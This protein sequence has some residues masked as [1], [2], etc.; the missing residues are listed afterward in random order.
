MLEQ[1]Q[2]EISITQELVQL[3]L[4]ASAFLVLVMVLV[5]VL[6]IPGAWAHPQTTW[7]L[8]FGG[9][10]PCNE[11]GR[12]AGGPEEDKQE[13]LAHKQDYKHTRPALWSIHNFTSC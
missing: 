11:L 4:S 12:V 7:Q 8:A 1:K 5:L 9:A 13:A 2:K 6:Y 3:E 10:E